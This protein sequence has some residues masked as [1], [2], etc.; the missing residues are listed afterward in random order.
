[1]ALEH[2][3]KF[4]KNCLIWTA[5]CKQKYSSSMLMNSVGHGKDRLKIILMKKSC[6]F[7]SGG[8]PKVGEANLSTQLAFVTLKSSG[9][10][11]RKEA[12]IP[13]RSDWLFI[14]IHTYVFDH[15]YLIC[16]RV[17]VTV[18]KIISAGILILSQVL[19]K[20]CITHFAV[21]KWP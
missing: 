6:I 15:I 13:Q 12:R 21:K 10:V 14:F 3:M 20:D 16:N 4:G 11:K 5:S 19:N 9:K 8:C 17:F 18:P 1:M 7:L 2:K